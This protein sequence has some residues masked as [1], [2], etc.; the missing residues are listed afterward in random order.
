MKFDLSKVDVSGTTGD[1]VAS[2]LSQVIDQPDICQVV[3]DSW[4]LHA[5]DRKATLIFAVDISH[6]ESLALAFCSNGVEARSLTGK[7]P[8]KDRIKIMDDFKAGLFPVLVNC[9]ILTEVN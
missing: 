9:A 2:R 6:V 8:S 7:T 3:F 4:K 5:G 1:F